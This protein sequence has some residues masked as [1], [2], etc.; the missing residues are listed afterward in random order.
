M[1]KLLLSVFLVSVI[2]TSGINTGYAIVC[3]NCATNVQQLKD[4]ITQKLQFGKDTISAAQGTITAAQQTIETVNNTVLIPMRDALTIIS[5]LKSGDN[6]KNLVLG[7]TGL[8]PLLVRNPEQYFKNKTLGPI[9]SWIGD[10]AAQKSIYSESI[11][12]NLLLNTRYT[13]SD[14]STKVK[15]FVR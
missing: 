1:K 4:S 9:Q 6:I 10:V 12:K 11:Y 15:G 8:D 13:Y 7:A 3:S 2:Y 14:T 5:I